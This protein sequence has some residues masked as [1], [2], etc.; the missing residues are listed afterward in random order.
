M[1]DPNLF[2][3]LFVFPILNVM[4]VFFKLFLFLKLPG[5]FGFAIISLT[6]FVRLLL[7]PFFKQQLD[8]AKKM[9]EVK[10]HLDKLSQKH[11]GDSKKLQEEQLKLYQQMGINPA[12]GCLF[13]IIQLPIFYALYNTLSLLLVNN[14][15]HKI[16]AEINKVVYAPF[17]KISSFDPWF[18]GIN[19]AV[20]PEKAGNVFYM[21]VPVITGVLQYFQAGA[22]IPPASPPA[23]VKNKDEKKNDSGDFQKAMNM[24]MKF[25][26]PFMIGFISY[27]MPVGLALYWNIFS[28]FSIIQYLQTKKIQDKSLAVQDNK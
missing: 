2:N 27:R 23:E 5:A 9:Q 3:Q 15:I 24:Q 28:L 14:N 12:S 26:F 10:P 6:V 21:L 17:L 25:L 22:M 4:M 19:L 16:I 18:F 7:Q 20:T 1:L 8:T 11:K 13:M